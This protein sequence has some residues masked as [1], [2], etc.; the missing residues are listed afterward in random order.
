MQAKTDHFPSVE[1]QSLTSNKSSLHEK[2]WSCMWF[3]YWWSWGDKKEQQ[4]EPRNDKIKF[5]KNNN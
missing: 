1:I 5:H 2:S 4:Y 3:L